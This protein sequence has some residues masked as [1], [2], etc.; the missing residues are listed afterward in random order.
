MGRTTGLHRNL[1]TILDREVRRAWDRPGIAHA[2]DV[3]NELRRTHLWLVARY[4]AECPNETARLKFY[5][6]RRP[7][8]FLETSP[9]SPLNHAS[10]LRRLSRILGVKDVVV[11]SYLTRLQGPLAT[12]NHPT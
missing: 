3:E 10:Y 6:R 9:R 11:R 5:L 1:Q 7:S 12:T 8:D 4:E 2:K